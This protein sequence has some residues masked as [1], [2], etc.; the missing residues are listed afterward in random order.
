MKKYLTLFLLAV[1]GFAAQSQVPQW[2]WAHQFGSEGTYLGYNT[3]RH[4]TYDAEGNTYTLG[5]FCRNGLLDGQPILADSAVDAGYNVTLLLVK[6][7]TAGR[8]LWHRTV[9]SSHDYTST[10]PMTLEV[11]DSNIIVCG[12]TQLFDSLQAGMEW[13]FFFDTLITSRQ[14]L[15][16]PESSRRPPFAFGEWTFVATLD[17]EGSLLSSTFLHVMEPQT[18]RLRPLSYCWLFNQATTTTDN[19]VFHRD[20]SGNNVFVMAQKGLGRGDDPTTLFVNQYSPSGGFAA[21][22]FSVTVPEGTSANNYLFYKFSPTWESLTYRPLVQSISGLVPDAGQYRDA[23]NPPFGCITKAVDVDEEGNYYVAGSVDI[24][25]GIH[26]YPA[27]LHFN[28]SGEIVLNEVEVDFPPFAL[29]LDA[30]GNVLWCSQLHFSS[31]DRDTRVVSFGGVDVSGEAVYVPIYCKVDSLSVD[32]VGN[33]ADNAAKCGWMSCDKSTGAWQ[34]VAFSNSMTNMDEGHS[35]DF[36]HENFLFVTGYDR[37]NY[38]KPEYIECWLTDGT[39]V[40]TLHIGRHQGDAWAAVDGSGNLRLRKV[41]QSTL[42]LGSHHLECGHNRSMA[43]FALYHNDA[44][45]EYYQRD[46]QS[47]IWD[48][49]LT[50]TLADSA[51]TLYATSTSSYPVTFSS[52]DTNVARCEGRTL[53]LLSEGSCTITAHCAGDIIYAPADPVSKTLII[54]HVGIGPNPV[55]SSLRVCPNPAKDRL[56]LYGITEDILAIELYDMAGRLVVKRDKSSLHANGASS[57]GSSCSI[58]IAHLPAGSYILKVQTSRQSQHHK[59]V[60]N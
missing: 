22:T 8:V 11:N 3:I 31:P 42:D 26:T 54:N 52:S 19:G 46:S 10:L 15:A 59:V 38:E 7:D 36:V 20:G 41:T 51:V 16:M 25:Y 32:G 17:L 47:I 53:Y 30:D 9:K 18:Q 4:M 35:T 23:V 33:F 57:Q 45:A 1:M 34:Q 21:D 29:K 2:E 12:K 49:V 6:Q 5:T 37:S 13:L 44:Y 50:Y 48:Q 43:V 58:S 60:K 28:G 39:P 55:A 56:N 24:G 14:V 40:D 27:H